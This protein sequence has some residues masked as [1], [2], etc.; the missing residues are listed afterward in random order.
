MVVDSAQN[1]NNNQVTV[2]TL[3]QH[4]YLLMLFAMIFTLGSLSFSGG[5]MAIEEPEYTVIESAGEF[6]LR[7]YAPRIVAQTLVGGSMDQAS[8]EGFKVIADYIFGNNTI[9]DGGSQK[10]SMTAPVTLGAQSEKINMTVPVSMEQADGQW[11]VDFFMPSEYTMDSLP[12]PNNSAVELRQV[13]ATNYAAIR[14][15]GFA[16]E[17]KTAKKTAQLLAWLESKGLTP[18]G[19]PVLARYNSP[20]SLPFLRRNEVIV[21]YK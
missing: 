17:I 18:V 3:A 13:P 21:P 6:E 7:T 4:R 8:T 16:G 12:V 1:R 15:S 5:A 9:S 19:E 20:V 10:I 14:F 11:R 2:I